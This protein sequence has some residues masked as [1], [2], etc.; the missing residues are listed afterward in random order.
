MPEWIERVVLITV[1]AYPLPSLTYR[2]TSCTAAI[3]SEDG[4]LRL[5]PIRFRQLPREKQFSKYQLVTLCMARHARDTRPESYRP[6]EESFALGK[7]LGTENGWAERKRWVLPT[8][9]NSMC[10]IQRRQQE[11]GE[12]LGVFRPRSVQ[13]LLVEW[14]RPDWQGRQRA[15]AAQLWFDDLRGKSRIR[16]VPLIVRY[17]YRCETS[18]CRGHK[19][20]IVDWELGRLYWRLQSKGSSRRL[21]EEK[22]RQKYLGQL[23]GPKRDT[24]FFVGNH[25]AHRRSFMVLGVFWPPRM[26]RTLFNEP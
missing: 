22:I 17:R 4:W 5:Y 25:S 16:R 15:A 10:E 18:G 20:R 12:S 23:C 24:Y 13:E 19:Q 1:K 8:A 6:D 7:V 2:E 26:G 9:R 14:T 11:T 21:I 3:S